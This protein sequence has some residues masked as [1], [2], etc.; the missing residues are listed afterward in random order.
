MIGVDLMFVQRAL[1][2]LRYDHPVGR[3]WVAVGLVV[4]QGCSWTFM[5]R[6]NS[7]RPA[8]EPPACTRG[9][10][11][12]V[13]DVTGAAVFGLFGVVGGLDAAGVIEYGDGDEL[14]FGAI[15]WYV[16]GTNLLIAAAYASSAATGSRW[17]RTCLNEHEEHRAALAV[18]RDSDRD[19]VDSNRV[20]CDGIDSTRASQK[21]SASVKKLH[22]QARALARQRKCIPAI[23]LS[24]RLK[25]EDEVYY[26]EV[27][28][29]DTILVT[30]CPDL[31]SSR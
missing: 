22:G 30:A 27:L 24:A 31:A 1:S 26:T 14:D 29:C 2:A 28:L 5:D 18:R 23:R 8:S 21:A 10:G 6:P 15:D 25:S 19:A 7:R 13:I 16:A 4:A 9:R 20:R 12:F 11:T 17:R 3:M